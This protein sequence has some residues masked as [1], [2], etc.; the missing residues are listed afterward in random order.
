[1]SPAPDN[2]AGTPDNFDAA[3]EGHTDLGRK[4]STGAKPGE[5][6]NQVLIRASKE[7]HDRW[8]QAAA[9]MGISMSE[10]VRDA[11]DK[12][13]ADLLDCKHG[14]Q[15]R[16]WYPWAEA[17]LKCGITLRDG[18]TWLVDPNSIPHVKPLEANPA[19]R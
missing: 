12:S 16:R 14:A 19:V 7:S 15:H 11:A 4:K 8:K 18:K 9:K 5:G 17:C 10:F 2:E 6:T 1:M 13:A 3:A